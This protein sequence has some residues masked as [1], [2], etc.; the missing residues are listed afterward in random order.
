MMQCKAK[1]YCIVQYRGRILCWFRGYSE[2]CLVEEIP[3]RV[4]GNFAHA[5]EPVTIYHNSSAAI[6]YSKDS[7]YHGKAKHIDIR[8][9]FVRHMIVWKELILG[10]IST[11]LMIA[12]LLTKLIAR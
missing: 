12:D 7:K 11:S 9:H 2:G 4:C 3:S 10:Y 6:V 8:Y 5:Q 1:L